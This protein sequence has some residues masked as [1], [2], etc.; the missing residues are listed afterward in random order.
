MI[1]FMLQGIR[2]VMYLEQISIFPPIIQHFLE[3]Y[4]NPSQD[5]EVSLDGTIQGKF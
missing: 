1:F 5:G 4:H 3:D 2:Q